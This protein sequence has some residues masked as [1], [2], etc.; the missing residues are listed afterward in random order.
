[1]SIL[2][3]AV[4]IILGVGI[5][6]VWRAAHSGDTPPELKGDWWSDFERQFRAYAQRAESETHTTD[7]PTERH[8]PPGAASV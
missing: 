4:V 3:V 6:T 2:L 8:G 5:F 7:N 1:M